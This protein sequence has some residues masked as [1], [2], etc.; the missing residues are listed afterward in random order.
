MDTNKYTHM[1]KIETLEKLREMQRVLVSVEKQVAE[2]SEKATDILAHEDGLFTE[3]TA[4][5][6]E[7]TAFTAGHNQIGFET[8]ETADR[9]NRKYQTLADLRGEIK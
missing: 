8:T 5:G 7:I 1:E 4:V 6:F 2:L 3:Y 9:A